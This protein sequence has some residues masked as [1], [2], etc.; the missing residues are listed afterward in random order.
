[1]ARTPTVIYRTIPSWPDAETPAAQRLSRYQFKATAFNTQQLLQSEAAKLHASDL[2][3]EVVGS[4]ELFYR[5]GT[6]IRS[7]RANKVA[8][9]GVVVHLIGTR[10]GDLRYSCDTFGGWEAN[11]RA[12]A[13]G[14]E[15]LRKVGKPWV[16]LR[17]LDGNAPAGPGPAALP[18]SGGG[19]NEAMKALPPEGGGE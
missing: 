13:L 7:D 17:F 11:L 5:D 15:A 3:V 19:A 6:G 18:A 8:H 2:I 16:N 12:V 9:V 14:L 10:F 1:M 4:S